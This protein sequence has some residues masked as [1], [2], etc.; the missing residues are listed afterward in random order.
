MPAGQTPFSTINAV[1]DD[2]EV[3]TIFKANLSYTHLFGNRYSLGA[4]LLVSRTVN[5][6]TYQ[7]ANLVEDPYFVS[8]SD[9]RPVFVPAETIRPNGS[10]DWTDSRISDR[11]GRTLLLTSDGELEQYALI[12]EG[13]ARVGEDGYLN[14]AF[15]FNRARDNSSYNCCVA[16]TSTFLPVTG[17]PRAL[18]WGISDNNFNHKLVVNG[19]T[20][21]WGGFNLGFTV[22]GS[23][24]DPYGFTVNSNRSANG[25]F[26]LRNDVA[27]LYDPNDPATP[28]DI[29]TAYN[30]ILAD[31]EVPG[32]YKTYL[33]DNFGRFAER[34]GGK[35]PWR[36]IVDMRAAYK[37]TLPGLK[38][39]LELTADLFN[40]AN[41]LNKDWGRTNDY[42]RENRLMRITGFDQVTQAYEYAVNT[43]VANEPI[44]GTPWRLQLGV[45]YTFNQ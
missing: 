32:H 10:T 35:A 23:G 20:P 43:G 34:N 29:R 4:N 26:N 18:N 9:G 33:S 41:L 36:A 13:T 12:F 38:H 44:N 14:A 37:L 21:S 11:I 5:N 1:S 28:E 40:V 25:D 42:G 15:T 3:P 39:G 17:D 45:R 6:Y 16:N 7:E 24:S 31:P 2:F 30:E 19:A 8:G 27:Y 22:I